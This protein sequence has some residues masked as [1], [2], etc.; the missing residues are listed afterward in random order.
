MG[1][2]GN[3]HCNGITIRYC[4]VNNHIINQQT[5]NFYNNK[6]AQKFTWRKGEK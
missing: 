6:I 3:L 5:L 4:Q 1:E 2:G